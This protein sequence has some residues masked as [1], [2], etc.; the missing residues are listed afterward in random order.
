M[1]AAVGD[2]PVGSSCLWWGTRAG[3]PRN[4]GSQQGLLLHLT[5][6]WGMG[7]TTG[8]RSPGDAP[9]LLPTFPHS[10][11]GCDRAGRGRAGSCLARLRTLGITRKAKVAPRS[12]RGCG[13]HCSAHLAEHHPPLRG[14]KGTPGRWGHAGASLGGANSRHP[15]ALQEEADGNPSLGP[16][17]GQSAS[18]GGWKSQVTAQGSPESRATPWHCQPAQNDFPRSL[19]AAQI[20]LRPTMATKLTCPSSLAE[21]ASTA[22]LLGKQQTSAL[23]SASSPLSKGKFSGRCS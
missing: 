14:S 10:E 19:S 1:L 6:F 22:L 11:A 5:P 2:Q 18:P 17:Y 8:K 15:K 21:G 3:V 20:H 23:K 12:A 4:A 13:Q 9:Q 7:Y 16:H